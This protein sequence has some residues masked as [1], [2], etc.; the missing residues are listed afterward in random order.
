MATRKKT[1]VKEYPVTISDWIV[2]LESNVSTNISLY[3]FLGAV[4]IA[5]AVSS[6]NFDIY[7]IVSVGYT[8][9]L[10]IFFLVV[11]CRLKYATDRIR[12]Y[13]RLSQKIMKGKIT[14]P[15]QVL[16][17]YEKFAPKL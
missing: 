4:L 5:L 17:E 16:E 15:K 1:P 13:Q 8:G 3:V 10:V 9:I 12:K 7:N 14:E 11:I 2:Y 6:Y